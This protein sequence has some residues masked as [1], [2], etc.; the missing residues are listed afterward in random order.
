MAL[1]EVAVATGDAVDGEV[2]TYLEI[3]RVVSRRGNGLAIQLVE[4]P[5]VV[6]QVLRGEAGVLLQALSRSRA[7]SS[8]KNLGMKGLR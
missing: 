1:T 3:G 5:V 6:L 2:L 7:S 8:S 4:H